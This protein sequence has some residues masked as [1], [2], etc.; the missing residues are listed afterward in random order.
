[1]VTQTKK[2]STWGPVKNGLRKYLRTGEWHY[3]K[4]IGKIVLSGSSGTT[5]KTLAEEKLA[6]RVLQ[7]KNHATH[8]LNSSAKE[9]I[10]ELIDLYKFRINS[11]NLSPKT[12]RKRIAMI[13]SVQKSWPLVP[14]FKTAGKTH[15]INLHPREISYDELLAWR[16]H[17][18]NNHGPDY[19]NKTVSMLREVFDIAVRERSIYQNPTAEMDWITV[20]KK[21]LVMPSQE[22]FD[23]F[24]HFLTH[25]HPCQSKQ[26]ANAVRDY[27]EGVAYTGLRKEEATLL[28]KEHVD[29]QNWVLN[30]PASIVKGRKRPRVVPL[31]GEARELFKRLVETAD[32]KTGAIFKVGKRMYSLASASRLAN[33]PIIM[34]PHKLRHYFATVAMECTNDP[35]AVASILGHGDGGKLALETYAHIR[36]PKVIAAASKIVFRKLQENQSKDDGGN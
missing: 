14:E 22:Q 29:L 21:K 15:L 12:I 30:L 24:L 11:G 6:Q 10:G 5:L 7:A 36:Q 9:T 16:N 31:I 26:K 1:M 34:T 8:A 13:G 35:Q 23:L 3:H 17:Y 32:P 4:R 19:T 20:P 33:L 25:L 28:C 18:R 27:V 2:D